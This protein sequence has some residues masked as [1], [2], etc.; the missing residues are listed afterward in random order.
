MAYEEVS[1]GTSLEKAIDS[2]CRKELRMGYKAIARLAA[3]PGY[4]DARVIHKAMKGI[5]SSYQE[6]T[7]KRSYD[8][9]SI[10]QR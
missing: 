1:G 3:N 8:I 4:Y 10:L 5:G 2:E 9:W 6:L 7:K